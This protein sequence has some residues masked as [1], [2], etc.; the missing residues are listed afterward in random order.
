MFS[1]DREGSLRV[2]VKNGRVLGTGPMTS[3]DA[4]SANDFRATLQPEEELL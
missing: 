2:G 3:A 1:E 4:A